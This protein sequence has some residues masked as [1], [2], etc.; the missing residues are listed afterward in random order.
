MAITNAQLTELLEGMARTHIALLRATLDHHPTLRLVVPA[1][2]REAQITGGA[3]QPIS[4]GNVYARMMLNAGA[5]P[6]PDQ[7][8]IEYFAKELDKLTGA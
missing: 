3:S 8:S 7:Q 4:L 5:V 6:P 2:Q 1:L